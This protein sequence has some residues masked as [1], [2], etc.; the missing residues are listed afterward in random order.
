MNYLR[1]SSNEMFSSTSLIRQSKQIFDK[2]QEN[3]IEKAV[4]LR[5]GK[6][7]F[8]M[9]DFENYEKIMSEYEKLKNSKQID[10]QNITHT[11]NQTK[12]Q[13]KNHNE[14]TKNDLFESE[15]EKVLD[16]SFVIELSDLSSNDTED[17]SGEIEEFWNK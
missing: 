16:Q 12:V 10:T 4:I 9:L 8:I 13:I 14:E 5:D 11:S 7:S 15:K 2:L 6:P 1:Y 17:I 3:E